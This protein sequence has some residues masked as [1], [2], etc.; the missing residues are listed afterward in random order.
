MYVVTTI[1]HKGIVLLAITYQLVLTTQMLKT[2]KIFKDSV[3][4]VY[5]LYDILINKQYY[6]GS[7]QVSTVKPQ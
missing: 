1:Y 5:F 4:L 3:L 7:K 2:I 6:W